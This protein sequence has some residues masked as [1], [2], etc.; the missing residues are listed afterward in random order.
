MPTPLD[1]K[2]EAM[3]GQNHPGIERSVT[4]ESTDPPDG[5]NGR[6]AALTEPEK[7]ANLT[8]QGNTAPESSIGNDISKYLNG[9]FK[10]FS[11]RAFKA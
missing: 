4:R 7:N 9:T 6:V 8:S 10:S 5:N 1:S 11:H 2:S 3:V